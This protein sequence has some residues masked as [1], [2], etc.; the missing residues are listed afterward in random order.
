MNIYV[1]HIIYFYF[2]VC[3]N[4]F[5]NVKELMKPDK[6]EKIN[7]PQSQEKNVQEKPVSAH[8]K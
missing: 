3:S 7:N 8:K 6:N 2:L 4:I 5:D 1:C